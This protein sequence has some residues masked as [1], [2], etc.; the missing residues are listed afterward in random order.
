MN[1]PNQKHQRLQI[2]FI[3]LIG[4]TIPCYALGY[5]FVTIN[6]RNQP[7]PTPRIPYTATY[8]EV[9]SI[10]NTP[11]PIIPTR[12]PTFTP[13]FTPTNTATRTP[14]QTPSLTPSPSWTP[15]PTNTYTPSATLTETV[16]P[17]AT[18]EPP[19]PTA[20]GG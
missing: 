19:P 12:F 1:L 14:S 16:I 17:P 6:R 3:V 20:T 2:L 8:T 13:S 11:A 10:T 7:T 15:Q 18:T 4:I 9:P 5:T